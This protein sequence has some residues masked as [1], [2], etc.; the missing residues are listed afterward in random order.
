[1]KLIDILYKNAEN[2]YQ[3]ASSD[4]EEKWDQIKEYTKLADVSSSHKNLQNEILKNS[5]Q[6]RKERKRYALFT[7]VFLCIFTTI[8][9]GIIIAIGLSK[10]T[11]FKLTENVLITLIT[12]SLSTIVG[13]FI[14]VMRYLFSKSIVKI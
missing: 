7:F 13:I 3:H 14:F 1:M 10:F 12:T 9:L 2:F 4:S 11:H 5:K 6:D 8:I